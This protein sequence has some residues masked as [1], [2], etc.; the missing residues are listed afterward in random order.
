[1]RST[2]LRRLLAP[3]FGVAFTLFAG[4]CMQSSAGADCGDANTRVDLGLEEMTVDGMPSTMLTTPPGMRLVLVYS[5]AYLAWD[6][7]QIQLAATGG[8]R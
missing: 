3:L 2:Y 7:A 8:D 4:L 1:M 6:T 5:D